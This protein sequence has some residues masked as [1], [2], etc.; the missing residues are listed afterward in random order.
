MDTDP[1]SSDVSTLVAQEANPARQRQRF[2]SE[3]PEEREDRLA[4]R[5]ARR[6]ERIASETAEQR[7]TRLAVHR[8][9]RRRRITSKSAEQRDIPYILE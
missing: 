2:E 9:R 3:M 1:G 8:A 5:R 6:R 4:R 7:K